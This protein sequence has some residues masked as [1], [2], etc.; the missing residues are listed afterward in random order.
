MKLSRVIG[1]TSQLN[2]SLTT[3][4]ETGDVAY[5]AGAVVVLVKPEA[6]QQAAYFTTPNSKPVKCVAFSPNGRFL[7]AGEAGHQPAV[8]VWELATQKVVAEMHGHKIAVGSLC[9][10]QSGKHL[11]S[12]GVEGDGIFCVWNWRTSSLIASKTISSR[13]CAVTSLADGTFVTSGHRHLKFWTL[14]K[15][16]SGSKVTAAQLDGCPA[17]LGVERDSTYTSVAGGHSQADRANVYGISA[18]GLLC[19]FNAEHTIE[20]YVNVKPGGEAGRAFGVAAC[21]RC[22]AVGCSDGIVRLFA[23][24]TL[25]YIATLPKPAACSR[26]NDSDIDRDLSLS[27]DES[28]HAEVFPDAVCLSISDDGKRLSV[29]YSD[30]SIYVWDIANPNCVGKYR[31]YLSHAGCVW[32]VACVPDEGLGMPSGTFATSSADSTVR[33]WNTSKQKA[34]QGRGGKG[35]EKGSGSRSAYSRETVSMIYC[36]GTSTSAFKAWKATDPESTLT[37]RPQSNVE[38]RCLRVSPDGSQL[39]SGDRMGNIRVHELEKNQL[40]AFHEA[41]DGEVTALDFSSELCKHN[42]PPR[43]LLASASKDSLVHIFDSTSGYELAQTSSDHTAAVTGLCFVGHSTDSTACRLVTCSSDK[44][45]AFRTISSTGQTIAVSKTLQSSSP[46]ARLHALAATHD[47]QYSVTASGD[48]ALKIWDNATGVLKRTIKTDGRAE[49][50]KVVIDPSDTL[51]AVCS[52]DRGIRL[53][54][55]KTGELHYKVR[56]HSEVVTGLT[57]SSDGSELVTVSADS[58]IFVWGIGSDLQRV[59]RHKLLTRRAAQER[60]SRSCSSP[61][62]DEVAKDVPPPHLDAVTQAVVARP[63]AVAAIN[64]SNTLTPAWAKNASI[65]VE[66]QIV[67]SARTEEPSAP[68]PKSARSESSVSDSSTSS[69]WAEAGPTMELYADP[70]QPSSPAPSNWDD[71]SCSQD[72]S[73]PIARR[74]AA[75][76]PEA[77]RPADQDEVEGSSAHDGDGPSILMDDMVVCDMTDDEDDAEGV[78]YFGSSKS[79][80]ETS[81][82]KFEVT[83]SISVP[84]K[85]VREA[86]V[87]PEEEPLAASSTKL[88]VCTVAGAGSDSDVEYALPTWLSSEVPTGDKWAA[89]ANASMRRSFSSRYREQMQKQQKASGTTNVVPDSP[90]RLTLKQE[91]EALKKAE[92]ADRGSVNTSR[93]STG[94]RLSARGVGMSLLGGARSGKDSK[95]GDAAAAVQRAKESMVMK[96]LKKQADE[97]AQQHRKAKQECA[98]VRAAQKPWARSDAS[99]VTAAPITKEAEDVEEVQGDAVA[100]SEP[101]ADTLV[102]VTEIGTPVSTEIPSE[103]VASAPEDKDEDIDET[104]NQEIELH[105]LVPQKSAENAVPQQS[106]EN[107]ATRTDTGAPERVPVQIATSAAA[108]AAPDAET[109]GRVAAATAAAE[110]VVAEVASAAITA[111]EIAGKASAADDD[112]DDAVTAATAAELARATVVATAALAVDATESQ[113]DALDEAHAVS[114]P[115]PAIPAQTADIVQEAKG[116]TSALE[117]PACVEPSGSEIFG[118]SITESEVFGAVSHALTPASLDQKAAAFDKMKKPG[119]D[120]DFSQLPNLDT[121][122]DGASTA[123]MPPMPIPSDDESED[124]E[125][126]GKDKCLNSPEKQSRPEI[127]A[128]EM[129][130]PQEVQDAPVAE[131]RRMPR[132]TNTGSDRDNKESNADAEDAAVGRP[133]STDAEVAARQKMEKVVRRMAADFEEEL[134]E[135]KAKAAAEREEIA[136]QLQAEKAAHAETLSAGEAAAAEATAAMAAMQQELEAVRSQLAAVKQEMIGK[137]KAAADMVQIHSTMKSEAA[138]AAAKAAEAL[139]S[140]LA[141]GSGSSVGARSGSALLPTPV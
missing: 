80:D 59:I 31:S 103:A 37:E 136:T 79:T 75:D 140:V 84:A 64:L 101:K 65:E 139:T 128:A 35:K 82:E 16:N 87:E 97:T 105:P 56:G 41:H 19:L 34:K 66:H 117:F 83:Q 134:A 51:M 20:R 67:K 52:S 96:M 90:A 108:T 125:D 58:C 76:K 49:P 113:C 53:Y 39:A 21:S 81:T 2:G 30:H 8:V 50:I 112:A 78:V 116:A 138:E 69:R 107:A 98:G 111:A 23:P 10:S 92:Q 119:K 47:G 132:S 89:D 63:Q 33:F 55:L 22:V 44:T 122:F 12:A 28:T 40:Y 4:P 126:C 70:S 127:P 85:D 54:D 124:T 45:I 109:T 73:S 102:H 99:T 115:S 94:I 57:F 36:G 18:R 15:P 114:G 29:I 13:V 42:A 141:W 104:R 71:V 110:A 3:N 130:G 137:E 24:K 121:S 11:A 131:G 60:R 77:D 106:T 86:A 25:Q 32:D 26:Q 88:A 48:Q 62:D 118:T 38:V 120:K 72:N 129:K 95:P 6:N 9:W 14:R 135:V 93:D 61:S 74:L 46:S 123:S 91:R 17:I 68:A 100:G 133:S 27:Y 5:T 7:A 43:V 1:T